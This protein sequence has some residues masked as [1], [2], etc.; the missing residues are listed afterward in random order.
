LRLGVIERRG[1]SLARRQ[2][3]LFLYPGWRSA[4]VARQRLPGA[5]VFQPLRGFPNTRAFWMVPARNCLANTVGGCDSA[6]L[7]D[8]VNLWLV[9]DSGCP[10]SPGLRST[11]RA[12]QR[13]PGA[14]RCH[15]SAVYR[16]SLRMVTPRNCLVNRV[17]GCDSGRLIAVVNLW[18]VA[19][20]GG[21]SHPGLRSTRRARLRSPGANRFRRSAA[22]EPSAAMGGTFITKTLPR[23]CSGFSRP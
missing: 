22:A 23:W 13:S 7:S 2:R 17:G 16:M 9:A 19:N 18:L 21:P 6:W 8:V 4:R 1:K 12:R 11:R 10:L 20:S 14:N 3:W 5:T 15:R